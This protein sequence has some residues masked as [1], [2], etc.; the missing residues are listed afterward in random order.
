MRAILINPENKTVTEIDIGKGELEDLYRAIDCTCI[1]MP[2]RFDNGDFLVMDDEGLLKESNY[3]WHFKGATQ[4]LAGKAIIVGP[5]TEDGDIL[6]VRSS[7]EEVAEWVLFP[8]QNRFWMRH[9][10]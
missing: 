1:C 2:L 4:V 8:A 7:V 9:E 6:P 3:F 10:D 5:E